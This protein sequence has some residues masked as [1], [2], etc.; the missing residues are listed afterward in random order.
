MKA[1]EFLIVEAKKNSPTGSK[2]KT[3]NPVAKNLGVTASGAG[4]HRDKKRD[5]KMGVEKH[6]KTIPEA[7]D[8]EQLARQGKSPWDQGWRSFWNNVPDHFNP[9]EKGTP[10]YKDWDQGWRDADMNPRHYEGIEAE[11]YDRD[12][13]E[14]HVLRH[15]TQFDKDR[16]ITLPAAWTKVKQF[17]S[18]Q[19]A[20]QAYEAMKAKYPKD[21]FTITTHRKRVGEGVA[22]G[23][24]EFL[25]SQVAAKVMMLSRP[26]KDALISH[27]TQYQQAQKIQQ[28]LLNIPTDMLNII[29]S[30]SDSQLVSLLQVLAPSWREKRDAEKKAG[31]DRINSKKG[32]KEGEMDTPQFQQALASVK[33]SAAQ[34]PK[35]TVYDP[36]TG[37]YKVVPVNAQGKKN[38]RNY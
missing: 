28:A 4:A 24:E 30:L 36:K 18:Y 11:A 15:E 3:R 20:K 37:K 19:E 31:L 26:E 14:Y 16:E 27:I 13:D 5:A 22:E 32:V 9:Y 29:K 10:E 2:V 23:S 33:K 17:D 8:Y 6:K 1:K 38:G 25:P 34:G 21:R 35:K 7:V 12:P